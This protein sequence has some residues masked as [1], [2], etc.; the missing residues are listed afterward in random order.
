MFIDFS[1]LKSN[2]TL[3]LTFSV[4]SVYDWFVLLF[5]NISM[6]DFSSNCF[7]LYKQ[8]MKCFEKLNFFRNELVNSEN[9]GILSTIIFNHCFSVVYQKIICVYI[10]FVY[11]ESNF[12]MLTVNLIV[13]IFLKKFELSIILLVTCTFHTFSIFLILFIFSMTPSFIS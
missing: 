8:E 5:E 9:Y 4:F 11:I 6:L 10:V 13:I 3:F 1:S 7:F 2:G 12:F